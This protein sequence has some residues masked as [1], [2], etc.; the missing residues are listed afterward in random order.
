MHSIYDDKQDTYLNSPPNPSSLTS[1]SAN[2]SGLSLEFSILHSNWSTND[3][4]PTVMSN[5]KSNTPWLVCYFNIAWYVLGWLTLIIIRNSSSVDVLGAGSVCVDRLSLAVG[6]VTSDITWSLSVF[7]SLDCSTTS[8][9]LF[10]TGSFIW[11][12]GA[13]KWY[14]SNCS[15]IDATMAS[16]NCA[17]GKWRSS[18]SISANRSGVNSFSGK[19]DV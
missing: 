2:N 3:I 12:F 11:A 6:S 8:A 9:A 10:S 13:Y 4:F 17:G 18:Q 1:F 16:T 15:R 14:S 5:C 7:V 19:E